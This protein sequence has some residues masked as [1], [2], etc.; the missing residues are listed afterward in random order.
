MGIHCDGCVKKIKRILYTRLMI[1]KKSFKNV[2]FFILL[3]HFDR[4]NHS[5]FSYRMF[6]SLDM[7]LSG[8]VC[9]HVCI[10]SYVPCLVF[11]QQ[12][13]V[14]NRFTLQFFRKGFAIFLTFCLSVCSQTCD[15]KVG[16]HCEGCLKKV[17]SGFYT[18][19]MVT[20]KYFIN[21]NF[22]IL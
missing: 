18:I 21:V 2:N 1:T 20:K 17:K 12:Q 5:S 7:C 16:I 6:L 10:S 11:Y 4:F 14:D 9:A 19:L 15:L 22:Y 3:L 8:C 13:P